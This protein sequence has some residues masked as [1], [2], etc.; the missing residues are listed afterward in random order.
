MA[1]Y[2]VK[3][4]SSEASKAKPEGFQTAIHHGGP[5]LLLQVSIKIPDLFTVKKL[6]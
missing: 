4:L 2:F 5:P 6:H 3:D 1:R